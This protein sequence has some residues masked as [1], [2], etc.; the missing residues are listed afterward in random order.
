MHVASR[1]TSPEMPHAKQGPMMLLLSHH[2]R[3]GIV[4]KRQG[5]EKVLKAENKEI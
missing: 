4:K 2:K 3:I 1:D 5:N